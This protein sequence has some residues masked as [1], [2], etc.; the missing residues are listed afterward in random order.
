MA[1]TTALTADHPVR[2]PVA[3]AGEHRLASPPEWLWG[4]SIALQVAIAALLTSYTYFFFDDFLFMQQARTQGFGLAYLREQLFTHFSPVS[5]VLDKLI[6]DVAPGSF[7]FAHCV[8]LVLYAAAIAALAFLLRTILGRTWP[9]LALT[10]L[11]GQSVFLL[12]LL[13]WWTA[14]ANVL[15]A[16]IFVLLAIAGYLRWCEAGDR[17]WLIA[18][19]VAFAGALCDYETAMLLPA[20]LAL[21]RLLVM[22]DSLDPRD[23]ARV[24]WRERWA[25]AGYGV[26]ELAAIINYYTNYYMK[27]PQPSPGQ[28]V[29][30]LEISLVQVFVPGLLGVARAPTPDTAAV[31]AASLVFCALVGVT[32]YLR[33]RAWRCLAAALLAFLISMVP[34]GLNRIHLFGVYIGAELYYQQSAQ[35]MF[36]VLAGFAF[37]RRWGGERQPSGCRRIP[38]PSVRVLAPVG[39]AAAVAYGLLYVASVHALANSS[40]EPRT[41]SSY[42]SRFLRSADRVKAST[43]R[44]PNLIDLTVGTNLMAA[45]F[46]PFNRYSQFFPVVDPRLRY[47]EASGPSFVVGPAGALEQVRL[48]ELASG[49]LRAATFSGLTGT[50]VT[51]ASLRAGAACVPPGPA[52]RLGVPL[53]VPQRLRPD[54]SNSADVIA[55][56]YQ[57]PVRSAVAVLVGNSRRPTLVDP[58]HPFV[59]WGPGR[60]AGLV[61]VRIAATANELE[62]DLPGGACVSRLTVSAIAPMSP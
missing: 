50:G 24:L 57:L 29:H 21:I 10:M 16:T 44:Q 49:R 30:F 36:L 38:R 32:L 11:F 33:P 42:V 15:P 23:W 13:N 54:T 40:W 60:G 31:L 18:S 5:R 34:L 58:D 62:L 56:H 41:A 37:S 35:F 61:V 9:A 39:L 8:Q 45:N 20:L 26:L 1:E 2:T 6:V 28:L 7:G 51:G 17:R 22:N 55:V 3:E 19:L 43:G 48:V 14:T 53:P 27:M 4:A 25:W 12:R 59:Y 52:R 47:D 46:A